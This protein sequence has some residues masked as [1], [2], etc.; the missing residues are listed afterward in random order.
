MTLR[1]VLG[2]KKRTF[3]LSLWIGFP[4]WMLAIIFLD[5][6]LISPFIFGIGALLFTAWILL[7]WYR[8]KCPACGENLYMLLMSNPWSLN[9]PASIKCCP[10]CTVRFDGEI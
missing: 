1:E 8:M 6:T 10:Y 5:G 4:L 9:V 3:A 7:A 2:K